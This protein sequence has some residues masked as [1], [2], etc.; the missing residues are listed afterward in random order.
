M[1]VH[2]GRVVMQ[3]KWEDFVDLDE[4]SRIDFWIRRQKRSA[5]G[6]RRGRHLE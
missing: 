6:K 3:A 1:I 4:D 2:L 5:G